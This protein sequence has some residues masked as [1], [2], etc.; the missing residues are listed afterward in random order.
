MRML[1]KYIT[2][3]KGNR[4]LLRSAVPD[5]AEACIRYMNVTTGETPYLIRE[6]GEFRMSVEEE[7]S[8]IQRNLED[9]RSLMMVGMLDHEHVGNCSIAPIGSYRRHAHR[10]DVGIALYQK[11]C[12][13][14][15]GRKM[16]CEALML[17]KEMGYEQAELEVIATNER[18]IKLYEEMGFKK[19]GTFP[20]SM[21]YKDGTYVDAYWM[22]MKL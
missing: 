7:K 2:D 17:A 15:I 10:C 20:D 1:E 19:Y 12:G 16:L 21:K 5:D 11:Y 3:K 18:A 22:M 9:S 13:L 14:G 4:V 8:F 6:L